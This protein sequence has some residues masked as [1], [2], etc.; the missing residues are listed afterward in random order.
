MEESFEPSYLMSVVEVQ[1]VV[2]FCL[3]DFSLSEIMVGESVLVVA[4][5]VAR[6][7]E[8]RQAKILEQKRRFVLS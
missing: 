6:I 2:G 7:V 4:E 3:A 8:E 1:D 5:R